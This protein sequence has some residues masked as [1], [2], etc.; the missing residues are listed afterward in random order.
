MPS[1]AKML[2][3]GIYVFSYRPIDRWER[4][5]LIENS[6]HNT[7]YQLVANPIIV[8]IDRRSVNTLDANK[9]FKP[10]YVK[11]WYVYQYLNDMVQ[12]YPRDF[13]W[14]DIE[15]PNRIKFS[16]YI[17]DIVNTGDT[18]VFESEDKRLF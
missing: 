4:S 2:R 17:P 7:N 1:P 14:L 13:K 12:V 15:I 8:Q 18:L 6:Y 3:R 9:E 16:T 11:E 10:K 5:L